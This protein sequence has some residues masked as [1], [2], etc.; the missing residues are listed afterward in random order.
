MKT[1]TFFEYSYP[2]IGSEFIQRLDKDLFKLNK[3]VQIFEK[4][5]RGVKAKSHV[6]VLSIRKYTLQILPKL[7]KY[8]EKDLNERISDAANNLLFMLSFT[9]KLKTKETG[10][11]KLRTEK[12][13]FYDAVV[14]LFAK[15]LLELVKKNF[16]REYERR[17]EILNHVKG[18]I[19]VRRQ[20]SR[21]TQEKIHCSYYDLT[22]NNLLNRTLKYTCYLLS[23]RTGK[24]E[25]WRLLQNILQILDGVDISPV[26][27]HELD[28]IKINRLNEEYQPFIDLCRLFLE[29]M[30]LE[31][32]SSSF[33]TF[34]LIFDMNYLFEEFIGLFFRKYREVFEDTEFRDCNI[35][36]QSRKKWLIEDPK[37][38]KLIPDIVFRDG[39]TKLIVDTKYKMLDISKTHLG[40]SQEDIYQMFAYSKK[41]NC[42]K[43]VLMYPWN[44]NISGLSDGTGLL[45]TYKFEKDATLY[46]AAVNL[47]RDLR[48]KMEIVGLKKELRDL[49]CKIGECQL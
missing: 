32:Q 35:L 16:W 33:R 46:I 42:K 41:F 13:N 20:V 10:L 40:I 44:E 22:Q 1:I 2:E 8:G 38:F 17:N 19:N 4:T 6:G 3:R 25:N 27:V 31:L 5:W 21:V 9:K 15:N 12:S 11:S 18:N 47:M 26:A 45:K 43:I 23:K 37:A 7:Y 14:Y 24:S 34:S 36:L 30:S 48:S 49:F 28:R 29:N 39:E